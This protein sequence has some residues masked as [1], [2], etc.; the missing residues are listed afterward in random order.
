MQLLIVAT[1]NKKKLSEIKAILK[2]MHLKLLA[3]DAYKNLPRLYRYLTGNPISD[4]KGAS[5][6]GYNL[7]GN[8]SR[9]PIAFQRSSFSKLGF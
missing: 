3:L 5:K 1:K 4:N 9:K 7:P 2:D 8:L 6:Q